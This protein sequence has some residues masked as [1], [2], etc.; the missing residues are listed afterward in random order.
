[1]LPAA[2]SFRLS[3]DAFS[4]P[5]L[6]M[7]GL[8]LAYDV[9]NG[10]LAARAKHLEIAGQQ[11]R[12]VRLQC[13][14]ASLQGAR[15]A[16]SGGELSF[17]EGE[18]ALVFSF[19]LDLE[20]Q[21]GKV[22]IDF[23][24]GG[25]FKAAMSPGGELRFSLSGVSLSQAGRWWPGLAAWSP[26]GDVSA[27]GRYRDGSLKAE[28]VLRDVGF[29][30]QTGLQAGENLELAFSL[31]ARPERQG[32]GWTA[33]ISW[34][35][36]QAYL[37]P[38]FIQALP[39][40]MSARGLLGAGRLELT[41]AVLQMP[42]VAQL[43]A[44]AIYSLADQRLE[45][46]SFSLA[47]GEL[48]VLGPTWIAPLIA[49]ANRE[50]VIF[51]GRLA[52]GLEW[53]GGELLAADFVAE[54]A[55]FGMDAGVGGEG[56]AFGP[57]N[58]YLPWRMVG[59]AAG[60]LSVEE[61]RWERLSLGHFSMPVEVKDGVLR[62][63]RTVIP[64][65]DGAV[66]F[67]DVLVRRQAGQWLG[68]GSAVIEPLSVRLLTEALGLPP[69]NGVLAASMP[70]LSFRPGE[71]TLDGALVVSVFDGYLQA[72]GLQVLEP[73]GATSRLKA[74]V[75]L[76]HIDLS[77]LT[78]TFSFGSIAGFVDADV[79]GLELSRW[80][81]VAFDARLY[82]S[83]GSYPRRISQRAVED[84]AALGGGGAVAAIQR[85]LLGLFR[86]FG[87]RDLALGCVLK[88]GV[89]TMSGLSSRGDG[90]FLI[91]QGGGLPALD[92]IGYNP[93][94][95][96]DELVGRLQRVIADEATVVTD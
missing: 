2:D 53:A 18:A 48:A 57:V 6:R 90:G 68:T 56:F 96:W 91:V 14:A 38:F 23:E 41:E 85:G 25:K 17:A 16:C 62:L 34:T 9:R 1:M 65:L 40:Q 86:D 94:V 29:S 20:L 63:G 11:W 42:G 74:D 71:I 92:V 27:E 8:E 3:L 60:E 47:G 76:R 7:A 89:C 26:V 69:M 95:D 82:S 52:A 5:G 35:A 33:D 39:W 24:D 37:E 45:R 80:R 10:R 70:G 93:R 44:S 84:L 58:G 22:E 13:P 50:A 67:D 83:R 73:L 21:S 54:N 59:E 15:L 31:S 49:P 43:A 78:E 81:P 19:S 79:A 88:E 28:G 61:G 77:Q 30:N 66:V 51:G 32:W 36:G 75:E 12:D 4:R 55:S 46:F 87:Y 72:T 64:L